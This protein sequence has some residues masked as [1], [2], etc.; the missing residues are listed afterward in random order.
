MAEKKFETGTMQR[1]ATARAESYNEAERTIE[2]VVATETPVKRWSW[3]LADGEYKEILSIKAE[4]IKM[5]R[6]EKGAVPFLNN[7]SVYGGVGSTLGTV[8]RAWIE[9]GELKALVRLSDRE[10][11]KP[12]VKDIKD[13]ILR[14]ISVGYIVHE[15]TQEVTANAT[16]NPRGERSEPPTFKATSWEPIEVS[17]VTVPADPN[18]GVRDNSQTPHFTRLIT[19]KDEK[20]SLETPANPTATPEQLAEQQRLIAEGEKRAIARMG[21][22]KRIAEQAG[23]TEELVSEHI[24]K[25]TTID[26]FRTLALEEVGK[27]TVNL[28]KPASTPD[29]H[30]RGEDE[31]VKK[32]KALVAG[33][34]LRSGGAGAASLTDEEKTLGRESRTMRMSEIAKLCAQRA[35]VNIA[36]MDEMEIIGRAIT[37][38]ASDFPVL[39]NDLMNKKLLANYELFQPIWK[40]FCATGTVNDFRPYHRIRRGEMG[41]LEKVQENGEYRNIKLTDGTMESVVADTYG[42]IANISRKMIINDDMGAM[43]GI[44]ASMGQMAAFS[45]EAGVYALLAQNSGLGPTMSDTKTL[46]HADHGNL[47]ASGG[48]PSI[49]QTTAMRLLMQK[50]KDSEKQRYIVIRPA[51]ALVPIELEDPMRVVVES[52]YDP[53]VS[54]KFQRTNTAKGIVK[55]VVS[56]PYISDV[57]AAA[58][59]FFADPNVAPTI[60]VSFLNGNETPFFEMQP[61]FSTDGMRYKIRHDWGIGAVDWRGAVRNAGA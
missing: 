22:F 56:S 12:I 37:T 43:N 10:D 18:A 29:A 57:S 42:G 48:A 31:S 17:L 47:I 53:D 32:R 51:I 27:R 39:L 4:H 2:V 6:F 44:A 45:I 25:G 7:H 19:F 40:E 54:N 8:E 13:G 59:Y 30:V 49:A 5:E 60:E 14:N 3:S 35:G 21:E 50:Q 1:S 55:N 16:V 33:M 41:L 36:G 34:M 61:A 38:S 26:Q 52:Q 15:F 20:M 24:G 28:G 9:G 58:Y 11:I 46:F 23:L